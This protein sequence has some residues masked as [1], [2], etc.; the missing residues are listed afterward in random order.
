[1]DWSA[2]VFFFAE[3]KRHDSNRLS[4]LLVTII[5]LISI[6]IWN[7]RDENLIPDICNNDKNCVSESTES[8]AI[9][10]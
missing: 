2:E 4:S 6:Y 3:P 10:L 1:M 5:C 9:S 7:V 8:M